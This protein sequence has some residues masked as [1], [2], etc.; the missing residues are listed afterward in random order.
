MKKIKLLLLALIMTFSCSTMISANTTSDPDAC[1]HNWQHYD[2]VSA[3][4]QGSN[5]TYCYWSVWST[6]EWQCVHCGITTTST[7]CYGI[8]DW[9]LHNFQK[10]SNTGTVEV[11]QCTH[12]GYIL[13][14]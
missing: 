13:Y 14:Q 11:Y 7:G 5:G 8:A 10:I 2:H 12:C 9:Q 4:S 3:T 6:C 1:T